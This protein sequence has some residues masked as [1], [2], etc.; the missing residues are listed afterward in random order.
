MGDVVKGAWHIQMCMVAFSHVKMVAFF[1]FSEEHCFLLFTRSSIA[2]PA[3]LHDDKGLHNYVFTLEFEN[4]WQPLFP[5]RFAPPPPTVGSAGTDADPVKLLHA[6]MAR[7]PRARQ[8]R[9]PPWR[10]LSPSPTLSPPIS[11][12]RFFTILYM[13]LQGSGPSLRIHF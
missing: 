6:I 4:S 7:L 11:T 1:L 10:G 8:P 2:I 5:C 13:T 3:R 9:P 12:L